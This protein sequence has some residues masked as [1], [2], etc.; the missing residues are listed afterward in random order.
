MNF[1]KNVAASW[2]ELIARFNLRLTHVDANLVH[3]VVGPRVV[4][5]LTHHPSLGGLDLS[6]AVKCCNNWELYALGNFLFRRSLT[7]PSQPLP[8]GVEGDLVQFAWKLNEV[9]CDILE[10]SERWADEYQE[11]LGPPSRLLPEQEDE[12]NRV[13]LGG[14]LRTLIF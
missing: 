6:A 4:L 5:S 14:E 9:G 11:V 3:V 13:A 12:L 10:G 7:R 8:D 2:A 1:P